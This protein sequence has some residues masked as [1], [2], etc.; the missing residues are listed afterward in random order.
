M[1]L[2]AETHCS[3]GKRSAVLNINSRPFIVRQIVVW[4]QSPRDRRW[5]TGPRQDPHS[6]S[7]F[8]PHR[9]WDLMTLLE[10]LPTSYSVI[11]VFP[12]QLHFDQN[13][14]RHN[15]VRTMFW[16]SMLFCSSSL[17]FF[18]SSLFFFIISSVSPPTFAY[19]NCF[20]VS[21]KCQQE[22]QMEVITFQN[23]I[24]SRLESE[25]LTF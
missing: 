22:D 8:M 1:S 7:L 23:K 17:F 21:L 19:Y 5:R 13:L 10:V 3:G 11:Y 18:S 16:S 12:H 15:E 24:P 6:S 20:K 4:L 2:T 25:H 9:V 14:F